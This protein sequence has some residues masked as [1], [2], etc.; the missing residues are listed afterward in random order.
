MIRVRSVNVGHA[1]AIAAKSG[2]SGIDKRPV[3]S[4]EIGV[5][6]VADDVIVDT[7]NHGG[8]E[9]AV[10]AYCR[11][12]YGWWAET[13][14]REMPDGLFGENLTLEGVESA[15]FHIGDVLEI[16]AVRLQVTSPRVPCVTLAARMGDP[17]F[18]KAFHKA[19]RFGPYFRVLDPG[20]I[21]AGAEARMIPF[22]GERL[23]I[24]AMAALGPV[25]RLSEAERVRWRAV[26]VHAAL[27]R[28]LG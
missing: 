16:G 22:D 5:E 6:G 14:G 7:D 3:T 24:A 2:R 17:G 13:L 28:D 15:D 23:P 26:P 25:A 20:R 10:Y 9:Q 8:P 18:V 12:D 11:S 19:A 27:R 4:I 21:T 1:I